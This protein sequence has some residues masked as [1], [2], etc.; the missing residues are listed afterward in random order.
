MRAIIRSAKGCQVIESPYSNS[1]MVNC[2]ARAWKS[3][4]SFYKWGRGHVN[5]LGLQL[6]NSSSTLKN[7]RFSDDWC[8]IWLFGGPNRPRN[9]PHKD[10]DTQ[11]YL[12]LVGSHLESHQVSST[13][14]A[15]GFSRSHQNYKKLSMSEFQILYSEFLRACQTS[16]FQ[17]VICEKIRTWN[18]QGG[19]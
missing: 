14:A 12:T 7:H 11:P 13:F 18:L 15:V 6:K 3:P 17:I 16:F 4:R 1:C 5:G 10:Q 9:E 8:A 2:R 19:R